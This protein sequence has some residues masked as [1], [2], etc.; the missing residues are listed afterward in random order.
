MKFINSTPPNK[1]KADFWIL[2][3]K[4]KTLISDKN[5]NDKQSILKL[6][7]QLLAERIPYYNWVGFYLSMRQKIIL[8][9]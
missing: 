4:I 8:L 7:S 1:K 5:Y 6:I 9:Y 2:Y 3:D